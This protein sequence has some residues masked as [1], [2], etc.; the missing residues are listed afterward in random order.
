MA[1]EIR[2]DHTYVTDD[3]EVTIK[4]EKDDGE[5]LL[6]YRVSSEEERQEIFEKH[7]DFIRAVFSLYTTDT[8]EEMDVGDK[9][10]SDDEIQ[11]RLEFTPEDNFD[12]PM[13]NDDGEE[14]ENFGDDY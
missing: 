10:E 9:L 5:A 3:G 7:E 8:L 4:I 11:E 12:E 13:Y 6:I 1:V 14:I 2:D